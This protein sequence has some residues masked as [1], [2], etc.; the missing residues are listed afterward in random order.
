MTELLTAHR[1][2]RFLCPHC[3]LVLRAAPALVGRSAPCPYCDE[4]LVVPSPPPIRDDLADTKPDG[5]PAL[6]S[7]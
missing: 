4:T 1:T 3:M 6:A 5:Y 2:V 7:A